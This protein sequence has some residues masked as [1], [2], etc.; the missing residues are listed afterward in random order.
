[1]KRRSKLAKK[2]KRKLNAEG[3]EVTRRGNGEV[4]RRSWGVKAAAALRGSLRSLGKQGK[5][6]GAVQ[7]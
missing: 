7:E 3:A 4:G 1:M 2:Q 6:V 5:Q